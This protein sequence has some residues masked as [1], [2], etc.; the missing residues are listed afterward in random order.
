MKP[1]ANEPALELRRGPNRE[2]LLGALRELDA[3]LP[4]RVPAS[5]GAPTFEST[6]PGD[7][8]RVVAI[9]PR[10]SEDDARWHA[11]IG[12][13]EGGPAA[14][15]DAQRQARIE[16]AQR[17][18]QRLTRR[19]AAQLERR[20]VGER[21]HGGASSSS[22]GAPLACSARNDSLDVFSSSRRTR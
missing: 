18:Q 12:R 15:A 2:A 11:G 10:S 21:L 1:F 9:A 5:S 13:L 17:G 6:D 4:L 7:P 20:L 16:L 3:R 22:S 19:R 8:S 14:V